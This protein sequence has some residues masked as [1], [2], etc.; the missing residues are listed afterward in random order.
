MKGRFRRSFAGC[1]AGD[2]QAITAMRDHRRLSCADRL[3]RRVAI[4]GPE[5]LQPSSSITGCALC[6]SP[7]TSTSIRTAPPPRWRCLI[8][9]VERATDPDATTPRRA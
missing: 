1:A 8:E 9:A 3:S 7:F 4:E 2:G 5:S 6:R